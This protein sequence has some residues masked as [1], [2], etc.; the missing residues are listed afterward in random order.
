MNA[1]SRDLERR[2]LTASSQGLLI[3]AQGKQVLANLIIKFLIKF[4][5]D[6]Y[7]DDE[8]SDSDDEFH[9]PDPTE[10]TSLVTPRAISRSASVASRA[11]STSDYFGR[12]AS[13]S[14]APADLTPH[15]T[16]A[17]EFRVPTH[18]APQKV[19]TPRW[20]TPTPHPLHAQWERDETV[21][22]CRDCNRRFNFLIRRVCAVSLILLKNLTFVF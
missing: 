6:D 20:T 14:R 16:Q 22:Q 9:Y 21:T 15:L 2:R 5:K 7:L 12:Q 10:T 1:Y 13:S 3:S 18:E 17:P 4:L 8:E 19:L 11:G